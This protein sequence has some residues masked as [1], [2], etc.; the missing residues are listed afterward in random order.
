MSVQMH[1]Y[2]IAWS[3][4]G[5]WSGRARLSSREIQAG[6]LFAALPGQNHDGHKFVGDALARGAAVL[7][8][9][10]GTAARLRSGDLPWLADAALANVPRI[11]RESDLHQG[12]WLVEV[13]NV[14]QALQEL[15]HTRRRAYTGTVIGV[16]GS[17]GKTTTKEILRQLLP[18]AQATQ[19]NL[20][21]HLGVP[22]SLLNFDLRAPQWICEMGMNHPG[23]LTRL[24]SLA[25]PELVLFTPLGRAHIG[26]ASGEWIAQAKTE[27][28]RTQVPPRSVWFPRNS[29]GY[30]EHIGAYAGTVTWYG[31]ES[32]GDP[33]RVTSLREDFPHGATLEISH[34][35]GSYR[36]SWDVPLADYA[37][38]VLASLMLRSELG[39]PADS[40]D[41]ALRA[42]MGNRMRIV[43]PAE[44][45][46]VVNDA[47]NASPE[48]MAAAARWCGR[49]QDEGY[50]VTAL[51]A[52]MF[53]LGSHSAALHCEALQAW[54][55]SNVS[56]RLAARA[57]DFEQAAQTLGYAHQP[58]L[59]ELPSW[60]EL[61]RFVRPGTRGQIVFAKGSNG[62]GL[63]RQLDGVLPSHVG[64][65][66]A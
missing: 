2:S 30:S 41:I 31:I 53:E 54:Q 10:E 60:H 26:E 18:G 62:S 61:V 9:A 16:T 66:G 34:G 33:W 49:R 6:D 12:M 38:S 13:N 52:D 40:V 20:N 36:A 23:E 21:N 58:V 64:V 5:S 1:G 35:A 27:L 47:Y 57:T 55:Q 8:C 4:P 3:V 25:E 28:L 48:T 39:L 22:I 63:G 19:G 50:G 37:G 11:L 46:W 7:L 29:P 51:L 59:A 43:E 65:A 17:F 42:Y 44:Q 24:G 45:Q 32:Q 56:W 15:A 14:E